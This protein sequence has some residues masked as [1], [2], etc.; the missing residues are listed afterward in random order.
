VPCANCDTFDT[1]LEIHLPGDLARVLAKLRRAVAAGD[2]NYNGFESSRAHIGQPDFESVDPWGPYPDVLDYYFD[3]PTCGAVF[4]L[5]AETYHG[6][7]GKWK[8]LR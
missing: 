5:T 6:S 2:L 7:G 4:E 8:R 3:C 1:Q